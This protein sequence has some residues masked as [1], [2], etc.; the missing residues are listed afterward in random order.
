M[1]KENFK[2]YDA[3]AVKYAEGISEL[4]EFNYGCEVR[5]FYKIKQHTA[6][7]KA[8]SLANNRNVKAVLV[9]VEND[10]NDNDIYT[11]V[12]SINHLHLAI[13]GNNL[14]TEKIAKALYVDEEH[15]MNLRKLDS[16]QMRVG[17]CLKNMNL[18][19]SHHDIF[20]NNRNYSYG[21]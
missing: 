6:S 12:Y 7:K 20:F 10:R 14:T 9:T 11:K 21:R 15:V 19:S 16:K 4:A 17:Y 18:S 2:K 8:E 3:E 5:T 1:K 13:E